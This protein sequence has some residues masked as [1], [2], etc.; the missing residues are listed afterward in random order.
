MSLWTA[1]RSQLR[2]VGAH[3]TLGGSK[4]RKFPGLHR[5]R[6]LFQLWSE[7][8][9]AHA[10][11]RKFEWDTVD[12]E[13]QQSLQLDFKR[14]DD[15]VCPLPSVEETTSDILPQNQGQNPALAVLYPNFAW[16][17]LLGE[18]SSHLPP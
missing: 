13:D 17:R 15:T 5:G 7:R 1:R 18:F 10:G 14:H 2:H 16:Q 3:T 12:F 8:F 11:A 4:Q 9:L 6:A